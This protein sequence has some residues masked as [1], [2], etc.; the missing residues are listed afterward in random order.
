MMGD[1]DRLSIS[2][3]WRL[4]VGPDGDAWALD[5]TDDLDDM[6]DGYRVVEVGP[7]NQPP[8]AVEAERM[9][10]LEAAREVLSAADYNALVKRRAGWP[11][12]E[13]GQ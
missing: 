5:A 3:R 4:M 9:R 6:C 1:V 11:A 7:V 10:W 8:G 13:R 2:E 12:P